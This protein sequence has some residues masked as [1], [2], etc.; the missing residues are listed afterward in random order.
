VT[1]RSTLLLLLLLLLLTTTTTHAAAHPLA[2][3]ED[4]TVAIQHG[5]LTTFNKILD[6]S[7]D[8]ARSIDDQNRTALHHATRWA[9]LEHGAAHR[10][11][12]VEKLTLIFD[13]ASIDAVDIFGKTAIHL[14]AE[15]SYPEGPGVAMIQHLIKVGANMNIQDNRGLTPLMLAATKG[16]EKAGVCLIESGAD[17]EIVNAAENDYSAFLYASRKG[18]MKMVRALLGKN[19]DHKQRCSYG[20]TGFHLAEFAG[21]KEVADFIRKHIGDDFTKNS[22]MD[23]EEVKKW[24]KYPRG[25]MEKGKD[26]ADDRGVETQRDVSNIM[27]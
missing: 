9:S 14:A 24:E 4:L 27:Q 21:H 16:F 17:V 8:S 10:L 3:E 13:A 19:I 15:H 1:V 25:T 12:M 7:L 22:E 11:A 26:G 2:E 20:N 23:P 6:D 18:R 5:D